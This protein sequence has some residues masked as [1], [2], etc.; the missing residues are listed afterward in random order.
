M[1]APADV[2]AALHGQRLAVVDVEGNGHNPPEIIE[3]AILPVTD[4]VVHPQDMR[5]WLI[6]PQQPISPIVTRKVH[7]IRDRDVADAPTW[8]QVASD[9]RL[10]LDGR[11]MVAHNAKVEQSVLSR[12]LPD[13]APPLVLDTLRLAKKVWPGMDG[14][15]L[16]KLIQH[17]RLD[18]TA[19]G[20]HGYHRAAYDSWAAWQLLVR[21]LTDSGVDWTALVTAAAT[22]EFKPA[23]EPEAGLWLSKPLP[24]Q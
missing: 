8:D 16:D 4:T 1:T 20:A 15:G 17:A 22:P 24:A 3:I 6:R 2:P 7:G 5:S 13:W 11:I 19:M 18:T 10:A 12:Q 21:L 9:I 14:Y 23:H